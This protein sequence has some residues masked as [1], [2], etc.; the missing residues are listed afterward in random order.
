[1]CQCS[2]QSVECC[3][4]FT[5]LRMLVGWN[6]RDGKRQMRG[7][8]ITICNTNLMRSKNQYTLNA[9][10]QMTPAS[11]NQLLC[12]WMR[13][14]KK[15][16]DIFIFSGAFIPF[17]CVNNENALPDLAKSN[18]LQTSSFGSS[19][20]E[21]HAMMPRSC[22]LVV[23]LLICVFSCGL[24]S[25]AY[26]NHSQQAPQKGIAT[27]TQKYMSEFSTRLNHKNPFTCA[28]WCGKIGAMSLDDMEQMGIV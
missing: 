2:T 18:F 23:I 11:S 28:V 8:N 6:V 27:H 14:E 22:V 15:S 19:Y 5:D 17:L 21:F 4:V 1:M 12:E 9:I 24:L 25:I 13:S 10:N 16:K 7:N 26:R 3:A 20:V